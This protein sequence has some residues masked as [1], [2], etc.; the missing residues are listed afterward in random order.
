MQQLE[1][2]EE[3]AYNAATQDDPRKLLNNNLI[4]YLKL[5]CISF[6]T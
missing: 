6:K 4:I 3:L 2:E 5:N 1:D